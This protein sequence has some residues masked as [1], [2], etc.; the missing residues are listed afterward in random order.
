MPGRLN[1]VADGL[2]RASEGTEHEEKDGSE[3]TVSEDWETAVSLSH[4]I[5]H[6]S[7]AHTTEMAK[8][9]D[10]FKDEPIFAEVIDDMLELDQGVSLKLRKRARHRASEYMIAEGKLWKIAGRHQE[11]AR[12]RV[13]CVSREEVIHLAK[14]EHVKNGH[15]QRDAIKKSLLDRI[16]CPGIDTAIVKGILDCGVCKNF[17]STHLHALLDPITRRHPFEL[18]VG[19][20]LSMPTGKGGY[21]TIGLYLDTYSQHIWGFKLKTAGN[22]K[23]TKESLNNIFHNFTPPETFMSDGGKHFDNNEVRQL[24]QEWGTET[25]VV[26][27]YSPWVNGLVEGTNKLLLHV[28]KRLCAP[29]LNDEETEQ[30]RTEDIPKTWPEHFDEAVRTLNGRLLPSLRFS[31][32]ELLL[33]LVVNTK[34]TDKTEA[35]LPVTETDTTIQMAYVAQQH[36]DGYAAAVAHALR[37]KTAFD[38]RVLEHTPG[39]VI[40]LKGQLVQ[41]YRSDLDFT[42]KTERKLLPKWSTPQHISSKNLNSY[43]LETL[44]GE[45]IQGTFSA[46]RLRRFIPREG[47]TLAEEQRH[48]EERCAE[49]ERL[50]KEEEAMKINSERMPTSQTHTQDQNG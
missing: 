6:T 5:F 19:D 45:P 41:I 42:F 9:R 36:L 21:H 10:R 14:E 25:H 20:Y 7:M 13:E 16:W 12:P 18:L 28:L 17:G 34:P 15:W 1:V 3:W 26:P 35:T 24:C 30:T 44:K 47:T 43:S 50:R 39:E 22:A 40:F 37:R 11:R 33:G 27:A 4:D 8:L 23:S 48:V 29:D 2:S 38:K 49:E 46:R 31:P 32:K